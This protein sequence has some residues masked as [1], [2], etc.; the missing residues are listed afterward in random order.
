[1]LDRIL[2]INP[3]EKYK[4]GLKIPSNHYYTV[5]RSDH[6]RQNSK[7]SAMFSPFAKLMSKINWKILNIEYLEENKILFNFLVDDYEFL[8]TINLNEIYESHYQEFLISQKLKRKG[9]DINLHAKLKT[10]KYEISILDEPIPIKTEY[11]SL[12]FDKLKE[13]DGGTDYKIFEQHVLSGLIDGTE[14]KLNEEL[15]YILKVIYSFISAKNKSRIKNNFVLKTQQN[16][17]IIMQKV[18][19]IYAE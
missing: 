1:M 7:D 6:E 18:A 8:V 4:S 14:Y 10:E 12:I 5:H 13:L 15:N 16:I 9:R 11:I 2:N 17:P 3:Q 19:I